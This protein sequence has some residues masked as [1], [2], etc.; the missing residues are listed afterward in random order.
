MNSGNAQ[1]AGA[2]DVSP[3]GLGRRQIRELHDEADVS[4]IY[5]EKGWSA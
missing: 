2:Q 5:L 3:G 4:T 1:D